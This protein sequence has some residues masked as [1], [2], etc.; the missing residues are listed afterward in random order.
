VDILKLQ[1]E[2]LQ[3]KVRALQAGPQAGKSEAGRRPA[4]TGMG[5]PGMPGMGMP[6]MPGMGMPGM[7]GG[8]PPAGGPGGKAGGMKRPGG[9]PDPVG[10]AEAALKALR[11]A[12]DPEARR[13]ATDALERAVRQLRGQ[14]GPGTAPDLPGRP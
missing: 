8:G 4:P 13:R 11:E 6:G 14:P 3:D 2:V 9:A 7:P 1:V 5:M 12:R 10:Q